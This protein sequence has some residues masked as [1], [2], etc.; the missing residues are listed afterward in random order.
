MCLV[1]VLGHLITK[2]SV[3]YMYFF[4]FTRW[5]S[6]LFEHFTVA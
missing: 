4:F 1:K 2:V 6:V 3:L 5:S